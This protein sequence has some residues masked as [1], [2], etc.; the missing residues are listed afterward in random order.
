MKD[1]ILKTVLNRLDEEDT[2]LALYFG[3]SSLYGTRTP[4][5]DTDFIG[6]FKPSTKSLVLKNARSSY[7]LDSSNSKTKNTKND[8][9]VQLNDIHGVLRRFIKGDTTSVDLLFAH[10]NEKAI[11]YLHPEF[12]EKVLSKIDPAI[13]KVSLRISKMLGMFGYVLS[14]TTKYGV[15]GT[16]LGDI[17]ALEEFILSFNDSDRVIDVIKK[18]QKEQP[19]FFGDD[20]YITVITSEVTKKGGVITHEP[21]LRILDSTAIGFHTVKSLRGIID[22]LKKKYGNRAKRALDS[23]GIDWKAVSHA[24]RVIYELI[25]YANTNRVVFPFED[26][27]AQHLINIKLGKIHQKQMLE[28]LSGLYEKA[29]QVEKEYKAPSIEEMNKVVDLILLDLYGLNDTV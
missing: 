19:D 24:Y 17:L 15:K 16:K 22:R 26:E 25:S 11:I 6:V 27:I 2:L 12:K 5:S 21:A 23:G 14:Q 20:K 3:G 28:E 13:G 1:K 4:T 9:D 29:V 7:R 18:L 10:T 8:I